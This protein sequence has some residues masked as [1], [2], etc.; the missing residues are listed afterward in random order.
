MDNITEIVKRC[1]EMQKK[2]E[3]I[4]VIVKDVNTKQETEIVVNP[5]YAFSITNG[6]FFKNGDI[7]ID[8]KSR[9]NRVDWLPNLK[10]MVVYVSE[11]R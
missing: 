7:H 5:S 10:Q 9:I 6:Q 3:R 4:A 2:E 1:E 8:R 11:E